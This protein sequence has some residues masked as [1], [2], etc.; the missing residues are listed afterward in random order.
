MKSQPN[1]TECFF[2][3]F[4][5]PWLS[6]YI[7]YGTGGK[8]HVLSTNALQPPPYSWQSYELV[9]LFH[10]QRWAHWGCERLNN[11]LG[12]AHGRIKSQVLGLSLLK[13]MLCSMHDTP[14]GTLYSVCSQVFWKQIVKWQP[15]N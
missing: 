12:T 2:N 10:S 13:S 8:E 11:G 3:A 9:C 6:N 15:K 14:K 7:V 5:K 1:I 4:D